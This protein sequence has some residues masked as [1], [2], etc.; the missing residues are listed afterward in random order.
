MKSDPN[1]ALW[2][3]ALEAMYRET[4]GLRPLAHQRPV[5]ARVLLEPASLVA[6]APESDDP[7]E[8]L[9]DAALGA[10]YRDQDLAPLS[11]LLANPVIPLPW[12]VRKQI[13]DLMAPE[14]HSDDPE[15]DDRIV[16][17][18]TDKKRQDIKDNDAKLEAGLMVRELED[19][20]VS[21]K[22]A[23]GTV[24]DATGKKE[25]WVYNQIEYADKLPPLYRRAVKKDKISDI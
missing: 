8:A 1:E 9:W 11:R 24:M 22:R 25:R 21:H 23:V 17:Q 18:R 5:P 14:S 2:K 19:R 16:F 12:R 20:G 13:A 4:P 10:I 3:A 7:N 6:M 15:N